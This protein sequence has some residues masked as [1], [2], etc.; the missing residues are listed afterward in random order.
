MTN[1]HLEP[2]AGTHEGRRSRNASLATEQTVATGSV[3]EKESLV[4]G[5]GMYYKGEM[6]MY[7][8]RPAL[9]L[10][11]YV[12][13]DIRKIKDYDTWIRYAQT[14]DETEVQ[15]NFDEAI[16]ENGKKA[17]AGLHF[18]AADNDLYVS[19]LNDK[20]SDDDDDFFLPSGTLFYDKESNEYK[21]ED[22]EKS[23]GNKLSGKVF[24]YNDETMSVRFEGPVNLFHGM[25]N[26]SVTATSI[27]SGS[28]QTNEI[29]MN[30]LVMVDTDIPAMAL[31]VMSRNL[32]DVIKNESV[33]EGL[34]DQTELLYKIADVVGEQLAKEYET[35]SLQGY[36]SLST[37]PPLVRPIVISDVN[38]KWSPKQ[39]AFYSEGLIGV[40]NILKNDINGG[41]EGFLEV[42]KDEAGASIFNLFIKAS[43]EAWYYL[44]FEGNRLLV[45]SSNTDFNTIVS[46]KTNAGKA[47]IGEVT[48]VPGSDDETLAFI[49]RFRSD[50]YGIQVPYDL[51]DG[52]QTIEKKTGEKKKVE[53]D[54]F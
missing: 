25:K 46:K 18:S 17:T 8:T 42:R 21:I 26:F 2:I 1:F 24:S 14:G 37:L 51:F 33:A 34:G 30:S 54:G 15:L 4:L 5:A 28:L 16:T 40:S 52:S 39:K 13:L 35:K 32:V 44:G 38:L 48:F 22:R 49:N 3:T 43:P 19:F 12:K 11:G 20:R 50:Y 27:G 36:T 6:T 31:D 41:F 10:T 23:A 9:Q 53:D 47:K 7:A 45:H 29:R